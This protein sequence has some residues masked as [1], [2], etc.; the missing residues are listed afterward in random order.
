MIRLH[1]HFDSLIGVLDDGRELDEHGV[2]L[3]LAQ[4]QQ[5]EDGSGGRTQRA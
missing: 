3:L 5:D 4:L 2:T 1:F